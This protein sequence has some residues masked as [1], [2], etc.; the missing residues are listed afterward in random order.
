M[1]SAWRTTARGGMVEVVGI[2]VLAGMGRIEDHRDGRGPRVVA[3]ND[4]HQVTALRAL[5]PP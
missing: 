2:K 3:A 1:S 5:W 4:A